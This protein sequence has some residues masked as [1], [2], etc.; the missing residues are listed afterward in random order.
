[1][2]PRAIRS[3]IDSIE[4][5]DTALALFS[6]RCTKTAFMAS[7]TSAWLERIEEIGQTALEAI[8]RKVSKKSPVNGH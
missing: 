8:V 2:R 7:L 6:S 3:F 4:V 1:M 5:L